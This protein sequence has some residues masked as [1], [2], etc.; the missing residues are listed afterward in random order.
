MKTIY[1]CLKC[2]DGV[3][4]SCR[5]V[6]GTFH[7]CSSCEKNWIECTVELVNTRPDQE[8]EDCAKHYNP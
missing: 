2:G 5:E 1:V 3:I 8:N 4:H 7:A 6:D